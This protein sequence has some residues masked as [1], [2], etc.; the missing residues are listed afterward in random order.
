MTHNNSLQWEHCAE[1][2]EAVAEPIRLQIIDVLR[3]GP[4]SVTAI[5]D[6]IRHSSTTV[7][8]HLKKLRYAKL[9][10]RRRRGRH[11]EY[12]FPSVTVQASHRDGNEYIDLGCCCRLEMPKR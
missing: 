6:L 2:I 9:V 11:I 10:E 12:S 3:T 7:S 8:F 5:S 4:H 1:Q